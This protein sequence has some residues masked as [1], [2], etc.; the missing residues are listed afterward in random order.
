MRLLHT[1]AVLGGDSRQ[2][3]LAELL[4]TS[5]FAVHTF[6]VPEL[7]DTAPSLE[8]AVSPAD[9]VC[10]PTPAITSGAITGLP[11]LTPAHLLSLLPE[12]AVV[13]GGSL[14]A[15]KTLL[16]KTNTPHYD[17][18]QNSA[19]AIEN[20]SLTAEGALLLALQAMPIAMQNAHVLVTGFGRIGKSLSAKLHALGAHVTITT[21]DPENF[22]AIEQLSCTPDETGFYRE[23]L[24]QYD[25]VFNTV[26]ASVFS[27]DQL[28][29][30]TPDCFYIELASSPGGIAPD[31]E[32]PKNYIL[33]PGLPGKT[34]PKTAARLIF[35][36][37]CDS[38]YLSQPEVS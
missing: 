20:A 19:L 10:L 35:R 4:S 18:L 27:G 31:A 33:A 1:F 14:G 34:A 26:P 8:E 11:E 25:A 3:Y 2:R 17:L 30:L 16:Q 32:K 15:C 7:P 23:G 37:M 9:A 24:S 38:P 22:S 5:G 6:A 28:E 21:R 36:A 29:A 13:F 12:H